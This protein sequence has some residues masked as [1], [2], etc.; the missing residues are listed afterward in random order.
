MFVSKFLYI[1]VLIMFSPTIT[2][3]HSVCW[4]WR[5]FWPIFFWCMEWSPVRAVFFRGFKEDVPA[6]TSKILYNIIAKRSVW[7]EIAF[8]KSIH[9]DLNTSVHICREKFV[10][11]LLLDIIY[12]I[13]FTCTC[14]ILTENWQVT[15]YVHVFNKE[16]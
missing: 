10:L 15:P 5:V 12:G 4:P 1:M 7:V 6:I 16:N 13:Q 2:L 9:I 8:Y 14:R 11:Y 3:S